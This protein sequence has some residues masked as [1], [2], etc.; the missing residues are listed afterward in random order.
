MCF[1]IIKRLLLYCDGYANT[2][3][4]L[5]LFFWP[6]CKCCFVI[7]STHQSCILIV[8]AENQ[9]QIKSFH[10][11]TYTKYCVVCKG[12]C[13]SEMFLFFFFF[14]NCDNCLYHLTFVVILDLLI[15][16]FSIQH[17]IHLGLFFCCF[18][19]VWR[20]TPES[21]VWSVLCTVWVNA[22]FLLIALIRK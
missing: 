18:L 22:Q 3:S 13:D 9:I 19:L 21:W 12:D 14:C 7:H 11:V 2:I 15:F 1:F 20:C 17:H 5:L 10:V 6:H 4:L 8:K 16:F